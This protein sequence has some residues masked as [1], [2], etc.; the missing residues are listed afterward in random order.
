MKPILLLFTFFI[1]ISLKAQSVGNDDI[2]FKAKLLT[3]F[4]LGIASPETIIQDINGQKLTF[5]TADTGRVAIMK[6]DFGQHNFRGD[7]TS[8][9]VLGQCFYYVAYNRD[10]FK[11]YRLGGFDA[12][13]AVEFFGD[14]KADE[15]VMLTSDEKVTREI[16][17]TC[18]SKHAKRKVRKGRRKQCVIN[19]ASTLSSYMH[20][21]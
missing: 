6:I 3:V 17:L 2:S 9:A 1:S 16:D 21:H 19:C 11:F 18:L 4:R 5:L 14:L 15:F 7:R 12:S 20:V 10:L 13:D 8:T